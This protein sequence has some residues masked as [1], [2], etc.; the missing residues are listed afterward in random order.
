MKSLLVATTI[1]RTHRAFLLPFAEKA[2]QDGWI[3]DAATDLFSKDIHLEAAYDNLFSVGWSRSIRKIVPQINAFLK[4]R[5][6]MLQN[7]YKVVHTHTPIASLLTR[8]AAA[9]ISRERRP[10]VI[11]TAHGFHFHPNGN[12]FINAI[13]FY[14]E[15]LL[16]LVTDIVIT[17]NQTD[18]FASQKFPFM[19]RKL[20]VLLPGIGVDLEKYKS[21][22]SLTTKFAN[23]DRVF[24]F[25]VVAEFINRKRHTDIINAARIC[26]P[27]YSFHIDFLGDGP[28]LKDMKNMVSKMGLES[29]CTFHGYSNNV[30]EIMLKS[31]TLLLASEQEGLPRCILEAMAMSIPVIAS[32]IRG[33]TDLLDN[34]AGIL[35]SLGDY[36]ALSQNMMSMMDNQFDV[37]AMVARARER[38][39]SYSLDTV[40][41]Q[42]SEILEKAMDIKIKARRW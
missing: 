1:E 4:I 3:V 30:K 24:R 2:K 32:R 19:S 34:S 39:L 23:V 11:Y 20:A 8:I 37:D 17:I 26:F 7:Q 41:K 9:T 21:Q 12:V 28:L 10:V 36:V 22:E 14:I 25:V 13:Y 27:G 15:N 40:L 16:S 35:Y 5:N 31:D 18:Y 42:Y 6:L 38:V 29:V 33:N